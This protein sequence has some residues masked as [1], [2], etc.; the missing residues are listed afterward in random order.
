[1]ERS[2]ASVRL[3]APLLM[4]HLPYM[5]RYPHRVAGPTA[6]PVTIVLHQVL[7]VTRSTWQLCTLKVA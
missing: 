7:S 4:S 3:A 2:V 1:M 5:R 6:R